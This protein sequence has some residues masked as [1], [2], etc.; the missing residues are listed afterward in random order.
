MGF[1]GL[2][3]MGGPMA[4]NLL[5]AGFPVHV[6]DVNDAAVKK[7][8]D[9]GARPAH[10][11]KEL[12]SQVE[13]IVTMLPSSPHF[14]QV[15]AGGAE[16]ILFPFFFPFSFSCFLFFFFFLIS[17]F[18]KMESSKGCVQTRSSLTHRPSIPLFPEK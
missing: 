6:F 8:K 13:Q 2:G 11:P 1:I 5:K 4:A 9:H 12:A 15:Y 3:N 16:Y 14:Q 18:K 10:S 7:L 17:F